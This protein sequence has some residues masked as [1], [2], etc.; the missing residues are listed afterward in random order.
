[1]KKSVILILLQTG[2]VLSFTEAQNPQKETV[3]FNYNQYDI[4]TEASQKLD[5]ICKM[6]SDNGSKQLT[7]SGFT[8]E[9]GSDDYNLTLSKQRAEAVLDYFVNKGIPK[10]LI[11]IKYFGKKLFV[12]DNETEEGKQA[13]RR[14]E[15]VYGSTNPMF[16]KASQ[17]F[18]VVTTREITITCKE[19]TKITFPKNAFKTKDGKAFNG[20]ADI[21]VAEFY[22][23]SDMLLNKLSTTSDRK[24]LETGGM[25]Y[26]DAKSGD[27]ELEFDANSSYKIQMAINKKGNF[28]LFYGDTTDDRIDWIPASNWASGNNNNNFISGSWFVYSDRDVTKE[29]W[30]EIE[31]LPSGTYYYYNNV[32]DIIPK[33]LNMDYAR[34]PTK[35]DSV[36]NEF[37]SAR[38][39]GW[40][41]CDKFYNSPQKTGLYVTLDNDSDASIYLIFKSINAVMQYSTKENNVYSFYNVPVGED[42]TIMAFSVK[43]DKV[44]Y[45]SKDAKITLL[46]K[47]NLNLSLITQNDFDQMIASVNKGK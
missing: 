31:K 29:K 32:I 41:N 28:Q 14:V 16:S 23:K 26:I 11:M 46:R 43:G 37:L 19:G 15:I 39:L 7:I 1:M 34:T 22:K 10:N 24:L 13:N 40:I 33:A 42:V 36:G 47:E 38:K 8:D 9:D 17:T 12:A 21:E 6:F 5:R 3:Y 18:K 20:V 2:F 35:S 25:V 44:Y 45:A 30:K 4:T 27:E